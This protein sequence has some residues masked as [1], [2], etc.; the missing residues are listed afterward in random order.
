M[1]D[2]YPR[3]HLEEVELTVGVSQELEGRET[4]VAD[5]LRSGNHLGTEFLARLVGEPWALLD[6]L[7]VPP[8]NRAESLAE[9][10]RIGAISQHL[11][12]DVLRAIDVLLDEHPV[13]TEGRECPTLTQPQ[14][15]FELVPRAHHLH[16]YST[17]P[18]GSL[19][20]HRVADFLCYVERLRLV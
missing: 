4:L 10:N 3:I 2:L 7:L 18:G 19:N 12:L 20:H 16:A 13:V 6:Y 11:E 14:G 9:V 17:T 8:L 5:R 1:L 15:R